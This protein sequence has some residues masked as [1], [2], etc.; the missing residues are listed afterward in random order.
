MKP[1]TAFL[2]IIAVVFSLSLSFAQT[3]TDCPAK[4]TAGNK[5]C[6]MDAA[7]A[8]MTSGT[9]QS[10][11]A[12]HIHDMTVN[13]TAGDEKSAK[14]CEAGSKECLMKGA[15]MSSE[16][17]AAEKANCEMAKSGKMTKA[18]DKMDCCKGKAKA[19]EAKNAVGKSKQ[20]KST[21]DGKGTN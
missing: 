11:T 1:R 13:N 2:V 12:L 21:A 17:T 15:K 7:K 4:S 20:D 3:K 16:C 6:C 19:S 10:A 5:S 9:K 8:S 18:S 14:H